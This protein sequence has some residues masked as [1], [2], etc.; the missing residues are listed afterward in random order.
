M[1]EIKDSFFSYISDWFPDFSSIFNSTEIKGNVEKNFNIDVDKFLSSLTEINSTLSGH[2]VLILDQV[3]AGHFSETINLVLEKIS[4]GFLFFVDWLEVT[5]FQLRLLRELSFIL[6]GNF[7]LVLIAWKIYGA[8]I[9]AKFGV[10]RGSRHRIEELRTSMS[11][12]QLPKEHDFKF[13]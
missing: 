8:R 4:E 7:I 10:A 13:K 6:L 5:D 9:A 1:N 3:Y 12:L 2:I 11:E